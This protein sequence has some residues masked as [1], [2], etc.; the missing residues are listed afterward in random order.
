VSLRKLLIQE[1]H[2]EGLI[3]HFDV[4]KTLKILKEHFYWPHL[5][6]HVLN[7][8][9]K[10]NIC[11]QFKSKVLPHG[12]YTLSLFL[13]FLDKIFQWILYFG[14]LYQGICMILKNWTFYT[15][16]QNR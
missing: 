1:D 14:C 3:G 15:M 10:S 12:L 8:C 4:N 7:L 9:E 2:E 5:K 16:P 11:K 13:I 6:K